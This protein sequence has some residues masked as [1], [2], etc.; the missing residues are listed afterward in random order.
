[1]AL[2]C[3][4]MGGGSVSIAI[5]MYFPPVAHLVEGLDVAL[6]PLCAD[7][8]HVALG[9]LDL[10]VDLGVMHAGVV[11]GEANELLCVI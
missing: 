1:M 10:A 9:A 5:L 6:E 3:K 11:L 8:D 7:A 4:S 2:F